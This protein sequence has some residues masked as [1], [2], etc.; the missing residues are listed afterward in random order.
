MALDVHRIFHETWLGEAQ[1]SEGLTFSVPVL[2]DGGV[3]Q[4]LS[5]AQAHAFAAHAVR[6]VSV[7][8]DDDRTDKPDARILDL[9]ACLLGFFGWAEDE[10]HGPDRQPPDL[11][12]RLAEEGTELRPT[13][14]IPRGQRTP[15]HSPEAPP[16]PL[17]AGEHTAASRAGQPYQMLVWALPPGLDLD[18]AE[19]E[20]TTWHYPPTAKFERLLRE[21]RVPMGLLANGERLR[22]VYCPPGHATG[23]IEFRV[24]YMATAPGRDMLSALRELLHADR[25]MGGMP[26]TPTTLELLEQ[27]R[28]RQADVTTR[29]G[30]QVREAL[31]ILLEGFEAAGHRDGTAAMREAMRQE[32]NYVYEGLLNVMLRLIFALYAEDRGLLPVEHPVYAGHLS[33]SG[34]YATL[35]A[36][37]D[38]YGD[39][40][41]Q[42]FGAWPRLIMLFRALYFGLEYRDISGDPT[43]ALSMPPHR[44]RLFNPENHA[45]LE[46]CLPAGGAPVSPADRAKT[47]LPSISDGVIYRVL[48]RL[49]VLDGQ[50]L[51][52]S[53]LEEEQLGSVYEGL[54]GYQIERRMEPS[55]CLAPS[56]VWV[57]ASDLLRL[58][59]AT[60]VRWLQDAGVTAAGAK[61]LAAGVEA[62]EDTQEPGPALDAEVLATLREFSVAPPAKRSSKRR[63]REALAAEVAPD[64]LVIQPGE[65]RRRTSSH[66]TPRSLSG[67]IVKR[68]LEPLLA[69]IRARV[70]R[71]RPELQDPQPGSEDLLS[72]KICDPA[73]GSGAFLVE[74]CR[75]MATQ[76]VAAWVR[77]GALEREL[78]A[79]GD[80]EA[81]RK[82]EQ[83]ARRIVAQRCLF[84]VDKNPL[85]VELGKLSLWL[86][87]LSR[88][89]TFTF[90]DHCLKAGDSLVGLKKSQILKLDWSDSPAPATEGSARKT[91]KQASKAGSKKTTTKRKDSEQPQIDLF[92]DQ[93][94][95]A[96]A[97]ATLAR[98]RL[99]A[100]A[101]TS[102]SDDTERR[103]HE[104]HIDAERALERLR[105]VADILLSTYFF[106]YERPETLT[107]E[108]LFRGEKVSDKDR[109]ACLA[110]VRDELNIWLMSAD[111]PP[112]PKTL[113]L[114]RSLIRDNIRPM[115]WELEFP[116]VFSDDRQDPLMEDG[117]GKAWV[118][119]VVGNPPFSGKNGIIDTGGPVYLT[120]LTSAYTPSHGNSDLSAYFF[121][122]ADWML[123]AH[124]TMGLIATNTIGQGDTRETGLQPLVVAGG[125][126]YD[127]TQNMTWP[128]RGANVSVSIVHIAKGS[129]AH[130]KLSCRLD[131]E[132][133]AAI[134]SQLRPT[135]ER[136]DPVRLAANHGRSFVG[137]YVLGKG[138]WLTPEERD[139]SVERNP[140]NNERV[141]PYLGGLELNTSPTQSHDRYVIDFGDMSLSEAEKWPDLLKI[142]RR[143]VKPERD[144]N[145]REGYRKYWWQFAE[146]R[147][148][149]YP[150]IRRFERCLA[151]SRHS[152]HC[153]FAFQPTDRVFSEA[154][155]IFSLSTYAQFG[156]LQSRIH[157]FWARLLGSSMRSDLRY[158]PS[159]CF[160]TFPF[161]DEPT[162]AAN[163]PLE[164]I[165]ERLYTTRAAYMV[166]TDQG[167]T[168]TYNALTDPTNTDPEVEKL[169]RLHEQLDRA[170]LDAYGQSGIE[171][172]P[173]TGAP[174]EQL[175]RFQDEVLEFLFARNALLAKREA[176][177]QARAKT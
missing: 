164:A 149:L 117:V 95:R 115:H 14:A 127:A 156:L 63:A 89:Q 143:D 150:T 71:E 28:E 121:R 130:Q 154:L 67:P 4:K 159:D 77:E 6:P 46:G 153:V 52:Y 53:A 22:L 108:F 64:R 128:V 105:D 126:I 40:M 1:P 8:T 162:L 26:D 5:A 23:W 114:R 19:S 57:G 177:A 123:G 72:L 92:A 41:D 13:L 7:D 113:E 88:G 111:S 56:R 158:G 58:P 82:P 94:L 132:V 144:T 171:V 87:T 172:P 70:A 124:G 42:R 50:R 155:V 54:M 3:M 12:L 90:L 168:K 76:L 2:C 15:T 34:L 43:K 176:A 73:M 145:N 93:T 167:L 129:A 103:Q 74:A 68:T 136:L 78:E 165:A 134:S 112:L 91:A 44:G 39:T 148:A 37:A 131:G 85:A 170:V 142:L 96:F 21:T 99:A 75:F 173:Y 62:L 25:V 109:K 116:E 119:A 30:E 9:R 135:S 27:S 55:V 166:A 59:R 141:F 160:E 174:P 60:R 51:S 146:K 38:A 106:P 17:E 137:S 97:K 61:R 29:L 81:R 120:W 107:P 31:Q 84:G 151:C 36:D 102:D 101:R 65:E 48:R 104:L 98:Q 24:G 163:K 161:P 152:K 66:Y 157:E 11:V 10:L 110:R 139:D 32:G 138:F 175:E 133:V 33:V 86:L 35:V 169:R 118:D 79:A 122:R 147:A 18:A 47:R 20:T 69:A 80:D 83:L 45:F 140:K 125:R 49:L 100:L 16:S